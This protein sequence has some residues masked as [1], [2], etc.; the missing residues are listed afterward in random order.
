MPFVNDNTDDSC[1]VCYV[2]MF[3]SSAACLSISNIHNHVRVN[4]IS[5]NNIDD[6]FKERHCTTNIDQFLNVYACK[7]QHVRKD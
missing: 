1:F 5:R 7:L 6:D 4:V 3:P 2:R